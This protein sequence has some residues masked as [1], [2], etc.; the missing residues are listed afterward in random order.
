MLPG[1]YVREHLT[2]FYGLSSENGSSQGKNMALTVLYVPGSL[3]NA[4]NLLRTRF[5]F[6]AF[7]EPACEINGEPTVD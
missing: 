4:R 2:R 1:P 3:D 6:A 7:V 5:D